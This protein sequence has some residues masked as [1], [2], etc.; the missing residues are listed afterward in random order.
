MAD[1][2]LTASRLKEVLHYDPETGIFIRLQSCGGIRAGTVCGSINSDGY[3]DI[4]VDKKLY[5]AHRLAWLFE[6]GS[7]P[8]GEIDHRNHIKTDNAI[9]NLRDVTHAVNL[10]NQ[11][12]ARSDSIIGVLG[13]TR[14]GQKF[15]AEITIGGSRKYLGI[16]DSADAAGRAYQTAKS[17]GHLG[18]AS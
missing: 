11:G 15:T 9:A 2:I 13:V 4:R 17:Q 6:T 7:W 5:R 12:R 1:E 18:Q 16:F 10:Q 8:V 3:L 14:K